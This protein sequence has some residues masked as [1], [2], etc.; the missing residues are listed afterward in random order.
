M[1][2]SSIITIAT[3]GIGSVGVSLL[4]VVEPTLRILALCVSIYTSIAIYRAKKKEK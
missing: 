2:D 4:H 1:K 3:T